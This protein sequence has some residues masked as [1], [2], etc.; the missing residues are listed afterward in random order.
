MPVSPRSATART[1]AVNERRIRSWSRSEHPD[2]VGSV[3]VPVAGDARVPAISVADQ[4]V[5][6]TG[7]DG[8][9]DEEHA[10]PVHAGRV[11]PVAVPV[12]AHR[13]VTRIAEGERKVRL[14]G[15][16]RVA[17]AQLVAALHGD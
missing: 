6:R 8:V 17:Y 2:G 1:T 7:G 10:V 12:A 15:G 4:E 9:A 3:A 5:G 11:D 16:E 13:L 14:A